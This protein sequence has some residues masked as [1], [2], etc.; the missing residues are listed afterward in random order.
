MALFEV[1]GRGPLEDSL[2]SPHDSFSTSSSSQDVLSFLPAT[3]ITLTSTT[4]TN[5]T[6]TDGIRAQ[7]V[8]HHGR[9]HRLPH[10]YAAGTIIA[11][12]KGPYSSLP[13]G[14]QRMQWANG[15][16]IGWDVPLKNLAKIPILGISSSGKYS[17]NQAF[18]Q[19]SLLPESCKLPTSAAS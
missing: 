16:V 19:I 6:S 17:H 12:P 15:P 13:V 2:A 18:R 14:C 10:P 3:R 11:K 9:P 4:S 1:D 8:R 7:C 5:G